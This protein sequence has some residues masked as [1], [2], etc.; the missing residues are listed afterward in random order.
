[1]YKQDCNCLILELAGLESPPAAEEAPPGARGHQRFL[2]FVG[3]EV[4]QLESQWVM[5]GPW[6]AVPT[7]R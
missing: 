6:H 7:Y 1:M 3:D 2:S 4:V 5:R